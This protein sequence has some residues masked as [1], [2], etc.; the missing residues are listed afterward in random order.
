MS[1][2]AIQTQRW[3]D[4]RLVPV[5]LAAMGILWF[6]VAHTSEHLAQTFAFARAPADGAWLS[7]MAKSLAA[8]LQGAASTTMGVERLH[9][10]GNVI[11]LVGA[12]LLSWLARRVDGELTT[13]ACAWSRRALWIQGLHVVEHIVLVTTLSVT[14]TA[15]G[16]TT[17]FGL[18]PAGSTAVGIR[19]VGH[20]VINGAA[21]VALACAAMG[22]AQTWQ[23]SRRSVTP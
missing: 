14:G 5:V 2:V 16:L 22:L 20:A 15:R 18:I 3:T 6:Q 4:R 9:L 10:V 19:V 11:V 23:R 7:S 12:L 1:S 21:T 17:G 13:G 8:S